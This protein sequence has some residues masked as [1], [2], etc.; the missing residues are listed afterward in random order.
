MV[1]FLTLSAVDLGSS[2]SGVKPDYKI[3]IS[4]FSS[5][6]EALSSKSKDWLARNQN[7]VSEESNM[8]THRLLFQRASTIKILLSMLV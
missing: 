7:K 1:S 6:H 2:P 5:K 3:G 4:C 8:S